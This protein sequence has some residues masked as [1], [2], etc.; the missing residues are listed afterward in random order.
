[1]VSET[2][3]RVGGIWKTLGDPEVKVGG[4]WKVISTIEIKVGGAWKTAFAV[5]GINQP[6]ITVEQSHSGR[7]IVCG[8]FFQIDGGSDL[9]DLDQIARARV[10][11]EYHTDEPDSNIG[12]NYDIRQASLT[13]G[14]WD[15]ES[16][17]VGTWGNLSAGKGWWVV[18][19]WGKGMENEGSDNAVGVFEIRDAATESI[20]A[21]FTVDATATIDP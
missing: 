12:P 4:A 16:L 11:G 18:R 17:T 10:A 20:L 3:I 13:S 8:V 1:M 9:V 14:I 15:F 2:K 7:Q 19:T 6:D 21:T 5:G